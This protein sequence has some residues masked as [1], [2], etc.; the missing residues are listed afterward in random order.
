MVS[1]FPRYTLNVTCVFLRITDYTN[2]STITRLIRATKPWTVSTAT[3]VSLLLK[4]KTVLQCIP[5]FDVVVRKIICEHTF[6]MISV[7]FSSKLQQLNSLSRSF[8]PSSPKCLVETRSEISWFS[9]DVSCSGIKRAHSTVG[10]IGGSLSLWN[11]IYIWSD[12][13]ILEL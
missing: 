12:P 8:S 10:I 3:I 6:I 7:R 1:W 5:I 13:V 2:I 11:K 9:S 4:A